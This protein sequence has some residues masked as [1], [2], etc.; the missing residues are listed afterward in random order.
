MYISGKL[1]DKTIEFYKPSLT[2]FDHE[3]LEIKTATL[4]YEGEFILP[5]KYMEE[6]LILKQE[7]LVARGI[8]TTK[9]LASKKYFSVKKEVDEILTL[10]KNTPRN[11]SFALFECYYQIILKSSSITNLIIRSKD[12]RKFIENVINEQANQIDLEIKISL[13][14]KQAPYDHKSVKKE[15][16][17]KF[18][19]SDDQILS[20]SLEEIITFGEFVSPK[21]VPIIASSIN[22]LEASKLVLPIYFAIPNEQD[23]NTFLKLC[24]TPDLDEEQIKRNAT[25]LRIPSNIVNLIRR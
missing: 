21:R 16:E 11:Y 1:K 13:F 25:R 12:F 10:I 20:S 17:A 24:Q 5:Q 6:K 4:S 23:A 19:I 22:D 3:K 9:S 2:N 18:K 8:A 7:E 14:L 15:K